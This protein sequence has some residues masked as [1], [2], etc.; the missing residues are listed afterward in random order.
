MRF[1]KAYLD[2]DGHPTIEMN[3]NL[4]KGVSRE[5][6]DDTLDWWREVLG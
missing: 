2:L 1:G 5:N 4:S 3:V 6:L